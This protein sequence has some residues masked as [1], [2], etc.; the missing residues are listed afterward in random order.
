MLVF[1]D[2]ILKVKIWFWSRVSW[3]CERDI[4]FCFG[5]WGGLV[6]LVVIGL[7]FVGRVEVF[8]VV[9]DGGVVV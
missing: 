7:V 6:G 8:R 1:L 5:G 4:L 9:D 2:S 3:F